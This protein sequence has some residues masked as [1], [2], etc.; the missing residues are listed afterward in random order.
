M[1]GLD[2]FTGPSSFNDFVILG[3]CTSPLVSI[4]SSRRLKFCPEMG[5]DHTSYLK[6]P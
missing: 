1:V 3:Q 2:Y 4:A 6:L 5:C